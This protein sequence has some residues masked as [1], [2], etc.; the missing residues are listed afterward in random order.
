M[1]KNYNIVIKGTGQLNGQVRIN[2]TFEVDEEQAKLYRGNQK[3]IV[4]LN[5]VAIH[6]SGVQVDPRKLSVNVIPAEKSNKT[7]K[8]KSVF[9][10]NLLFLPFRIIWRLF[11][12]IIRA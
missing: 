2:K 12:S 11:K 3:D 10:G 4:I 9:S 7:G 8:S 1:A 5:A 6:Y